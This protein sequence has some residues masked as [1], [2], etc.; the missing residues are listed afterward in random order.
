MARLFAK[1][2]RI[3]DLIR[4][5]EA[6]SVPVAIGGLLIA[7]KSTRQQTKNL[8]KQEKLADKLNANPRLRDAFATAADPKLKEAL[9]TPPEEILPPPLPPNSLR[10]R[11]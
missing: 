7:D 10:Q 9:K 1:G 2:N 4:V 8:D 11:R 6:A 5:G 3:Q